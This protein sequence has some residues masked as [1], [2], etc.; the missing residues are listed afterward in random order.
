[1]RGGNKKGGGGAQGLTCGYSHA[2]KQRE[3]DS[4]GERVRQHAADGVQKAGGARDSDFPR[5]KSQLSP[6]YA[7]VTPQMSPSY[8]PDEPQLRPS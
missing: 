1:M 4:G 8:A 7:R 3:R 5:K 2:Q 6:S